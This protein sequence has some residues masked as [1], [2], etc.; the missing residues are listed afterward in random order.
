MN[1]ILGSICIFILLGCAGS[2]FAYSADDPQKTRNL[3][4]EK[5][6]IHGFLT[7]GYASLDDDGGQSKLNLFGVRDTPSAEPNM[8][9]GTQF[10]IEPKQNLRGSVQFLS[11]GR[12]NFEVTTE[13]AYFAY[14]VDSNLT[15]RAG[16][17]RIPFYLYSESLYVGYTYPWITPPA[18]VYYL[19]L[20]GFDGADFLFDYGLGAQWRGQ[21]QGFY[22]RTRGHDP[23]FT[24]SDFFMD[25]AKG[26]VFTFERDVLTLRAS[27]HRAHATITPLPGGVLDQLDNGLRQVETLA[28]NL[29]Q[30]LG[31]IAFV[32]EYRP[33]FVDQTVSFANVALT[34]DG[35]WFVT[36]EYAKLRH[37]NALIP[38]GASGYLTIGHHVGRWLPYLSAAV[39]YTDDV[40]DAPINK[41]IDNTLAIADVLSPLGTVVVDPASGATAADTA[42]NLRTLGAALQQ[43][44]LQ[45]DAYSVGVNYTITEGMKVKAEAMR[46]TDFNGTRGLFTNGLPG[47]SQTVYSLVFNA[48]F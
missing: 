30:T 5:V 35:D 37:E 14:D 28:R 36:A 23:D 45:Q 43:F 32:T 1:T 10:D 27:Y 2:K 24:Q 9:V 22:G 29:N 46:I 4:T 21:I 19:P 41:R 40:E 33:D 42:A 44:R 17:L 13:W 20:S 18:E 48:V 7:A 31:R 16:R 6:K 12:E 34:Y 25:D 26:I 38:G 47:D 8:I 39:I 11:R 15:L 3:L